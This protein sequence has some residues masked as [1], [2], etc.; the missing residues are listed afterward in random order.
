MTTILSKN[1]L[2]YYGLLV[3]SFSNVRKWNLVFLFSLGYDKND[4]TV[5]KLKELG[6]EPTGFL[7]DISRR[8]DKKSLVETVIYSL[9]YSFNFDFHLTFVNSKSSLRALNKPFETWFD[10]FHT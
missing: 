3:S 10:V 7:G 9:S 2:S 4:E 6:I 5:R 1:L 8:E